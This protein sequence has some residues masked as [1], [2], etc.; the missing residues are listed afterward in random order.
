MHLENQRKIQRLDEKINKI[1][2]RTKMLGKKADNQKQQ[3]QE[4]AFREKRKP[5]QAEKDLL[6]QEHQFKL[7][8]AEYCKAIK[9]KYFNAMPV[10]QGLLEIAHTKTKLH[11]LKWNA[12]QKGHPLVAI[13]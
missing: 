5:W 10:A 8:A 12:W 6:L 9:S 4:K 1:H 3:L 2:R 7:K 11:R 13:T